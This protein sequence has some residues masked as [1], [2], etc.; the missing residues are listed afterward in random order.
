MTEEE[1]E[2]GLE[3]EV[4]PTNQL[5]VI[6][7]ETE[8]EPQLAEEFKINF[9]E[10]FNMAST[11]AKKAKK[12]IVTDASQTV[13]MAEARQARL[14]LREKRLEIEKFRVQKKEYYLNAGRAIDKVASFL[15]DT[16]IPTEEHLSRQ[17]NFVKLQKEAEDARL[18]AEARARQEAELAEQ[19]KR[20]AEEKERLRVENEKLRKEAEERE[21][22][23]K[24]ELA[25]V[26]RANESALQVE[27]E[28]AKKSEE[29]LLKKRQEEL[30]AEADKIRSE[31]ALA[32][33]GDQ[34]KLIAFRIAVQAIVIPEVKSQANKQLIA[35]AK[36]HLYLAIHK[37]TLQ[38]EI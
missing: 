36:S 28:R 13:V 8:L 32:K 29:E 34:E 7:K 37:I 1:M 21:R 38:E 14:F 15:K 27:R 19:A 35:D 22:I 16:I 23:N 4:V 6:I 24:E 11:W 30:R 10:H 33:A 20:D 12:I 9:Q 18:L 25:R 3:C 26:H 2:Q 5:Q 17:E 31:E